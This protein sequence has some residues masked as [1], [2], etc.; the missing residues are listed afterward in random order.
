MI[1]D[2]DKNASEMADSLKKFEQ[3]G[4]NPF[5][6]LPSLKEKTEFVD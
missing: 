4:Y 2:I 6:N 1:P 3:T 5:Q